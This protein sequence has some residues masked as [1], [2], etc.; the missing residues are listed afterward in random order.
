MNSASSQETSGTL[1]SSVAGS[2]VTSSS[3]SPTTAAILVVSQSLS[4][5]VNTHYMQYPLLAN[6]NVARIAAAVTGLIQ[7]MTSSSNPIMTGGLAA[8]AIVLSKGQ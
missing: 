6:G 4:S 2:P 1:A 8:R 5:G 3:V 7:P